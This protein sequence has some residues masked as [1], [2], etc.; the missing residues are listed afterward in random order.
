MSADENDGQ[1]LQ[2]V[3]NRDFGAMQAAVE[4]GANVNGS[5]ELDCTPMAADT[6]ADHVGMVDYLLGQAADPDMPIRMQLL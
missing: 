5:P 3:M 4:T 1:L 6:I 2:G